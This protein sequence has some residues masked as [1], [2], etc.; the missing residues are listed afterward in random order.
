MKPDMPC[1][2]MLTSHFYQLFRA[3]FLG[4][5]RINQ[6]TSGHDHP[7]KKETIA[8]V[9]DLSCHSETEVYD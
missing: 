1:Y 3:I 8:V 2:V 4:K 6:S 5:N 9:A 7:I